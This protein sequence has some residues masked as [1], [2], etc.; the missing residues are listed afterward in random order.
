MQGLQVVYL[1]TGVR[2]SD[3]LLRYRSNPAVLYAEPDYR[4]TLFDVV[5]DDPMFTL[6][7]G[8]RNTG[9]SGGLAGADIDAVKAW[10]FLTGS[11]DV[12]V[13]TIDTGVDW[14]HPDLAANIYHNDGDCFVNGID[15]DGNGFID[16]CHGFDG[17]AGYGDPIDTLNHG[18]HVAGI[19]GATGNNRLGVVG[20]NWNVKIL[21]CKTDDVDG[22]L[23]DSAILAC[24]EYMARMKD[25]GVNIVATNNSYGGIFESQAITDGIR[26]QMKRGIL[27]V[28]AAGNYGLDNDSIWVYP[29][30]TDLP[31]VLAVAATDNSDRLAIF[32]DFGRH[33]VHLGAPGV[34]ITSTVPGGG[35]ESW[36]GTSMATPYVAGAAAL[37]Q[38][39]DAS[40]DW[41]AIKNRI[42]AGGDTLASMSDTISGRRLN[43]FGSMTCAGQEVLA[44]LQPP[45]NNTY[46]AIGGT[47]SFRMLHISCAQ[48]AGELTL[49]IG[50][51][52]PLTLR[53]DGQNGDE[54]AGDGVY[55]VEW[56]PPAAGRY[57]ATF[58]NGEVV[59]VNV[60]KPYIFSTTAYKWRTITGTLVPTDW[61]YGTPAAI[62]SPFPFRFGGLTF[63]SLAVDAYGTIEMLGGQEQVGWGVPD[64]D[65]PI[66][67]V[68]A[69][70]LLAPLWD[71][72][73]DRHDLDPAQGVYW[74]AIGQ[75]PN[76]ELVVEWRGFHHY[77][78]FSYPG[79]NG[80]VT[81]QV[82]FS[83]SSDDVIFN[84][85]DTTFDNEWYDY[86]KQA[87]VGIQVSREVG[88]QFSYHAPVLSP[89]L[90]V[91]WSTS[92][93]LPTSIE[94]L[95]PNGGDVWRPG[96]THY[97]AWSAT[98]PAATDFRI[99]LLKADAIDSVITATVPAASGSF[100]WTMPLNQARGTD[101][102]IR[103]VSNS[104]STTSHTSASSFTVDDVYVLEVW[105]NYWGAGTVTSS[106][107]G[108]QCHEVCHAPFAAGTRLTLAATPDPGNQFIGWDGACSGTG[109]CVIT[110]TEDIVVAAGFRP[111]ATPLP[112][113]SLT[114]Q[115]SQQ[116]VTAGEPAQFTITVAGSSG[117]SGT[118]QFACTAGLP[119]NSSCSF[120]P[121]SVTGGATPV[122]TMLTINTSAGSLAVVPSPEAWQ[123][124]FA[125]LVP[126]FGLLCGAAS[127]HR[128]NRR[129]F[130]SFL[131]VFL[132][133][134]PLAIFL[135][136]GGGSVSNRGGRART[137]NVT[138]T[139]TSGNISHTQVVNLTLQ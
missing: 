19:I 70:T 51:G 74:E 99:E 108:I 127:V 98:G 65:F 52:P 43:V 1:A 53:D 39:Y 122:S 16:D 121:P 85:A 94:I 63:D 12:V 8:L 6:L 113:F 118:V 135:G 100:P 86:G 62:A 38:A 17:A 54:A 87:S 5:P 56:I 112:D 9:Q 29:A 101:Y 78:E 138:V 88:M 32:S 11:S 14:N 2:V 34:A 27:F 24:L 67:T 110:M 55:S 134:L 129:R 50:N 40:L 106:P 83:E 111:E 115:P 120:S 21:A 64:F 93:S 114:T 96:E 89:E 10:Q 72:I 30:N 45:H 4:R 82:A 15:D 116:A 124:L 77:T 49:S 58:S 22:N 41:V 97:I 18:T 126:A 68:F 37:L 3:A 20:V 36:E 119:V 35:Y 139:A 109:P 31:N 132:L 125:S 13:G 71:D 75:A 80:T 57:V 104:D 84:Y 66:P 61:F 26:E 107:P 128:S 137:Y 7:W 46:V 81:L 103:L 95:W 133:V 48:P 76:R 92:N 73:F 130:A 59:T 123:S 42:L 117:F 28:A 102:K 90:A 105:A 69:D 136:C 23:Y 131:A 33:T 79:A 25:K 47:V 91:R 60:L 44:R